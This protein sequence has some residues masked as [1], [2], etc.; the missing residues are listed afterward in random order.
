LDQKKLKIKIIDEFIEPNW[1]DIIRSEVSSD[2]ICVGISTMTGPQIAG[3]LKFARFV[4]SISDVPIVWGGIHP[5]IFPKQTLENELVDYVVIGEGEYCFQDLINALAKKGDVSQI[6]NLGF[7]KDGRII[8]NRT[9]PATIRLDDL[10]KIPYELINLNSYI[11]VNQK[12]FGNIKRTFEL[13]TGRGCQHRCLYCYNYQSTW[14]GFSAGRIIDDIEKLVRQYKIDALHWREDNFFCSKKRVHDICESLIKRNIKI[15][16]SASCRIDYFSQYE[17]DFVE[18]LKKS[19]LE[20]LVFGAES[21]SDRILESLNKGIRI[22]QTVNV[23]RRMKRFQIQPVYNFMVGIPGEMKKDII[24]TYRLIDQILAENPTAKLYAQ[25]LYAPYPS[26][27]LYQKCI[28][29]G[30]IAP[31]SL[32]EWS[33]VSFSYHQNFKI[34]PWLNGKLG[35]FIKQTSFVLTKLIFSQN[36]LI[37]FWS[38]LRLKA[39]NQGLAGFP[40]EEWFTNRTRKLFNRFKKIGFF[41]R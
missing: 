15:K 12:I 32:Q 35:K 40:I 20:T 21:G 19:G 4:R 10:P 11:G 30:F 6:P 14:R 29:A 27:P 25:Q 2:T 9:E 37:R 38:R 41:C 17:D 3:S 31:A 18:L 1:Q 26:T 34:Y 22:E 13:H 7:K 39:F 36:R 24:L 33:S 28:D 5:T 8:L 23:N 16:W